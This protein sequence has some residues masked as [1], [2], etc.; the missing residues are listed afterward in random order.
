MDS[1]TRPL[2]AAAIAI[3]RMPGEPP[4]ILPVR[5]GWLAWMIGVRGRLPLADPRLEVLRAISASLARGE[6][7]IR[8][9]LLVAAEQAG[10]SRADLRR[11]F[12]D[13]PM[14]GAG[15]LPRRIRHVV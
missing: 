10:W 13:A 15:A 4:A 9:E 2:V 11:A 7:A 12:P 3:G 6:R 1:A 5:H 14:F 8:T